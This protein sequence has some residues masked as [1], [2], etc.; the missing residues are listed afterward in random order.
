M[1]ELPEVETVR[2]GLEPALA[3][4][5][6]SMVEARRPDLRFPLPPRFAA[7][8]TGRRV[9][10]LERRGKYLLLGLDGGETL[11][12]H[13]GMTGRFVVENGEVARRP[14]LHALAAAADPRHAH[15]VFETA[16][17]ARIT[18]FDARRFGFMDLIAAGDLARHPR[19][20]GMGPEPLGEAFHAAYLAAAFAARRQAVKSLL[21]DQRIVA[22]IGNIYACEALHMARI[23]PLKPAGT[24]KR[25]RL[26]QLV[27]AV[28]QVLGS[29]I[30]AGGSSLRDFA[31]AAGAM[32]YFQHSF[33]VY[34]RAGEACSR[35]GC[36]GRIVRDVQ[37][38]RSSFHCPAC[39]KA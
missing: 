23:S 5:L 17:G 10:A 8:L 38:G 31:D 3:G 4:A 26:Q 33:Q 30:E 25:A 13:L 22:G 6:L 1:P 27:D 9:G 28:R 18:Y 2:R 21:L 35:K 24:L 32:G 7:R 14:G 16:A 39:Q 12:I 11:L 29:A 20:A 34:G 15:V 19:L 37:A 36:E